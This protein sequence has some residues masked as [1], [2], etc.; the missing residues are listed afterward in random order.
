MEEK[1]KEFER[2]AIDMVSA[3][4]KSIGATRLNVEVHVDKYEKGC[5]IDAT[6]FTSF[7][8]DAHQR[9]GCKSD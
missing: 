4:R 1:I 2:C 7:V 5:K 3:M 8:Q 6:F 9:P